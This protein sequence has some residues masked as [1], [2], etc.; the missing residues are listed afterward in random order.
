[1]SDTVDDRVLIAD[2]ET[3]GLLKKLTRIHVLVVRDA[4]TRETFVFRH[5]DAHPAFEAFPVTQPGVLFDV[6]EEN[7]IPQ[8]I[9]MLMNG[10]TLVGH[11][12]IGFDIPAMRKVYPY[13]QPRGNVRDSLVLT[14]VIMP[15]TKDIDYPMWRA[16]RMPGKLVGK[17]SLDAWGYR[18]GARKGDY[19]A[20]MEKLGKDPWASWNQDMEDYC[21]G[22]VDVTEVLWAA[23]VKELPPEACVVDEHETHD[24]AAAIERNGFPFNIGGALKLTEDLQ[25][26]Y[27]IVAADAKAAFG[28]WYA[29]EK[30]VRVG[31][32]WDD[33]DGANKKKFAEDMYAIETETKPAKMQRYHKRRPAFG[34]NLDPS[35][36]WWGDVT[37]PKRT[38]KIT[39]VTGGKCIRSEAVLN[40]ETGF[41]D[42]A[43]C[44]IKQMDFNPGSRDQVID[45]FQQVYDWVPKKH[46]FTENGTPEINDEV[47]RALKHIP[48]AEK[49]A[50]CFFLK[51]YLG[52]IANGKQ[53]WTKAY[54]Q[55]TGCIHCY[56]NT[57]GTVSGRCSH[58]NPNLGQVPSVDEKPVWIKISQDPKTVERIAHL[59]EMT[60]ARGCTEP[61]AT[62]ALAKLRNLET[63]TK[64]IN[65]LMLGNSGQLLPSCFTFDGEEKEEA[66]VLGRPGEYGWECRSLFGVPPGW[67]QCGIDLSGI[68][69]RCLAELTLPFDDGELIDVIRSGQDIHVFNQK[70][71]GITS[72]GIIK[73]CLYGLMYGAGDYK[74]GVT[75]DP[76]LAGDEHLAIALGKRIREQIM[77]GLPAL[78]EAIKLVRR[79]AEGGY[80]IGLDGRKLHC[81]QEYSAL[82]LRLQSNAAL[83]AKK[84]L[85]L[86]EREAL[87]RGWDHGW[88]SDRN[89]DGQGDFA[90]MAFVHD[91]QQSAVRPEFIREFGKI[92]T[93]AALEA[94]KH[95]K[96]VCPIEAKAK[97]GT[98]WAECH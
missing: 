22:D 88:Y 35:R 73:R 61:E 48:V 47:L 66:P 52:Q 71:T 19:S 26:A 83:L 12:F 40:P 49:L 8:G 51:K 68:E 86:T 78:N 58:V 96:F 82:N 60:T 50:E 93:D 4:A 27:E 21:V 85:C 11:N 81:R 94:G 63:D 43:Y 39:S 91:E 59:K 13:F 84:W 45:R 57:G 64:K 3:D 15:D 62:V 28:P 25:Y 97:F 33:P 80:L 65:P 87:R 20:E 42:H 70:K 79:Q 38:M 54:D 31:I 23:I 18:T 24:L 14:R 41:Y 16:G 95:F 69:F 90:M 56:I 32:E 2:I 7:T 10:G 9:E 92:G 34:E 30:K 53:S 1:M 76:S 67:L 77:Q 37:L 36:T 29:P 75:A 74:L 17:H 72:R 98:T 5:R 55:N 44:R 6:E 46:E 89:K